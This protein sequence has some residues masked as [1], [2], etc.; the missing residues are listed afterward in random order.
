VQGMR[1]ALSAE[2]THTHEEVIERILDAGL[3]YAENVDQQ[4]SLV[5]CND[6]APAQGK[7]YQAVEQGIP[8]MGDAEF[9]ALIGQAVGGTDVEQFADTTG[10][11]DQYALF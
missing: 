11:G 2:T 4:T 7:G 8:L 3:A 6:A 5:V 1:I 9:M 10:D